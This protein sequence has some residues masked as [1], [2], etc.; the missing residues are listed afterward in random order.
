MELTALGAK[1]AHMHLGCVEV[2]KLLATNPAPTALMR[3]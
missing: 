3:M 2:E 1:L